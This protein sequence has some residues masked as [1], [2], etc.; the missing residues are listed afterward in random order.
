MFEITQ[1]G[2]EPPRTPGG[3]HTLFKYL[4]SPAFYKVDEDME[5]DK[6]TWCPVPEII[7]PDIPGQSNS[8]QASQAKEPEPDPRSTTRL[9]EPNT[10]NPGRSSTPL[11]PSAAPENKET[12][13]NKRTS[14]Q[15]L[16]DKPAKKPRMMNAVLG[17][18][19]SPSIEGRSLRE[20]FTC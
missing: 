15:G 17:T 12:R 8:P 16:A 18:L 7:S 10:K 20:I 6:H 14:G 2:L 1:S 19:L 9:T 11:S 4:S 5:V 13:N 3:S